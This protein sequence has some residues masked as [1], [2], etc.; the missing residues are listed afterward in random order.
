MNCLEYRRAIGA[1]P[2]LLNADLASHAGACPACAEYGAAMRLLNER[3]GAALRIPVP[4]GAALPQVASSRRARLPLAM[5]ASFLLA[6]VL[7]TILW[8]AL[9][10]ASLARDIVEHLEHEAAALEAR[11]PVADSVLAEVL[12]KANARPQGTFGRVTYAQ[13]CWFRDHFVPHLVVD[14]GSGPV[15]VMLLTHENVRETVRFSEGG[16]TG[17]IVPAARG[18]IAVLTRDASQVDAI[19]ARL[20]KAFE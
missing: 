8:L 3:I 14:E 12:R 13:S 16:Y 5:A 20:A 7:A 18:S 9:P 2:Q 11:A 6:A 19:A 4:P 1:D 10:R 17:V 15:T